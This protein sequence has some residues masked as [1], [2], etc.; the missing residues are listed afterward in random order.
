MPF[1]GYSTVLFA[2]SDST[3]NHQQPLKVL[4]D[5]QAFPRYAVTVAVHKLHQ[6]RGRGEGGVRVCMCVMCR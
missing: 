4:R 3:P 2:P 1:I 5:S 6:V